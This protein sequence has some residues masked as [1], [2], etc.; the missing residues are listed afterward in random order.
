MFR[1]VR[2]E[3]SDENMLK[4]LNLERFLVDQMIPSDRKAL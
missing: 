1:F 3:Q 4:Q 2:N